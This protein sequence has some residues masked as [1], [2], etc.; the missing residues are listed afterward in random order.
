MPAL[1]ASQ[2]LILFSLS[3]C[4]LN[5]PY[6]TLIALNEAP[7]RI[8]NRRVNFSNCFPQSKSESKSN[9]NPNPN[10]NPNLKKSESESK[11]ECEFESESESKSNLN[12]NL[13]PI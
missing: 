5:D 6:V 12:P 4:V 11:S 8:K 13:N 3:W 10:L 1:A 7:S 9:L 2:I